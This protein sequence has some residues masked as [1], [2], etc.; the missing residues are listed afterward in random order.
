MKDV[1]W[2]G[3]DLVLFSDFV[4]YFTSRSLGFL[5]KAGERMMAAIYLFD[6]HERTRP[7]TYDVCILDLT[8]SCTF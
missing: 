7:L 8:E 6:V 5:S 3:N 1:E 4:F 2:H